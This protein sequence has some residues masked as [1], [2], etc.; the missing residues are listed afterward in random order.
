M[1]CLFYKIIRDIS[2]ISIGISIP[3]YYQTNKIKK[4]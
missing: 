4:K 3:V 1:K 2:I